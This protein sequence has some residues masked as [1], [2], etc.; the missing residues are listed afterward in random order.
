MEDVG[1]FYGRPFYF[2]AIRHTLWPFCAFCGNL[3]YFTTFRYVVPGKIWQPCAAS[4]SAPGLTDF[5]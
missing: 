5:S 1:I 2:T 3:V 4:R